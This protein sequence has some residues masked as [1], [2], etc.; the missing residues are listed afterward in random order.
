MGQTSSVCGKRQGEDNSYD[1]ITPAQKLKRTETGVRPWRLSGSAASGGSVVENHNRGDTLYRVDDHL[2]A[3]RIRDAVE[4]EAAGAVMGRDVLEF[5]DNATTQF[6][7]LQ[8]RKIPLREPGETV[9]TLN[10][11]N[12]LLSP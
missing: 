10:T 3:S 1:N 11:A 2:R 8:K 6:S 7:P 5:G 4:S 9:P 12:F